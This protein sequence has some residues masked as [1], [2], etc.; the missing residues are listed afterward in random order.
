MVKEIGLTIINWHGC[1]AT[2]VDGS[3]DVHSEILS[4]LSVYIGKAR[5][6]VCGCA[7]TIWKIRFILK[8]CAIRDAKSAG[9]TTRRLF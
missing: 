9:H 7:H 2:D 8:M 1:I 3:I 4:F 5:T 6:Q